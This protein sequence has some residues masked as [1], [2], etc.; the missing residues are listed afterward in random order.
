VWSESILGI[1]GTEKLGEKIGGFIAP[2]AK[3]VSLVCVYVFM[4]VG[5]C[6]CM[7]MFV[8]KSECACV[9]VCVCARVCVCVCMCVCA[10]VRVLYSAHGQVCV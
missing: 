5:E 7:C 9:R 3:S 6:W 10:H 1:K 4:C 2:M 8:G